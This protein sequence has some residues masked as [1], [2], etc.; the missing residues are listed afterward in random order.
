VVDHDHVDL[1]NLQRQ[2]LHGTPDLGR[3]KVDSAS[4]AIRRINPD[5]R[6]APHRVHLTDKNAE[7]LIYAYD[8]VADGSDSFATR[9]AVADA[10]L[11][12]KKPLVSAAVGP[13]EGQI[14]TFKGYEADQPCYRCFVPEAPGG[15]ERTCAE[16]G[17]L[18]ALTG[19]VGALQALEAI[20]EIVGFGA[21]LAGRLMLYDALEA[22]SRTVRL[23]KDPHCRFC[24][25]AHE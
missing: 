8:I 22:R 24:G 4:D 16:A 15:A 21:G 1:S 17:V 10:C 6:V 13:F 18:G 23:P 9:F 14:A 19:V 2:V 11:A 5:V 20:R 3:A 12:L 7:D 25:G